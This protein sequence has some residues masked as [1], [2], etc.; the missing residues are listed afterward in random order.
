[1]SDEK[2]SYFYC[3]NLT[4]LR[5][6]V[7]LLKVFKELCRKKIGRIVRLNTLLEYQMSN[8]SYLTNEK[9]NIFCISKSESD[10]AALI[11]KSKLSH[12]RVEVQPDC[13]EES[14]IAIYGGESELHLFLSKRKV[15]G[16][17]VAKMMLGALS[18]TKRI[19]T[20]AEENKEYVLSHLSKC[21]MSI[22]I[23]AKPAFSNNDGLD[24]MLGSLIRYTDGLL[25]TGEGFVNKSGLFVLDMYGNYEFRV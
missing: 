20:D 7:F 10:I 5:I 1:M 13:E 22:G 4:A 3:K 12:V 17:S 21:D 2:G 6:S 23:K 14:D 9:C 19:N 15:G 25:F 16:D 8:L 11:R 24:S 18:W